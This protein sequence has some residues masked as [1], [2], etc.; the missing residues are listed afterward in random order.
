MS[1]IVERLQDQIDS[2]L[3]QLTKK[4]AEIDRLRTMLLE[5]AAEIE[6]LRDEVRRAH[7]ENAILYPLIKT[8]E[9]EIERLEV[10]D[11]RADCQARAAPRRRP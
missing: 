10:I 6:R 1:D 7:A 8:L 4:D 2:M 11:A 9:M 5:E 3:V